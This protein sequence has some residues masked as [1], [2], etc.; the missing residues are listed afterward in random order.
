MK[1]YEAL[2]NENHELRMENASLRARLDYAE[3]Q[4]KEL[5]ADVAAVHN[6]DACGCDYDCF[7]F[8]EDSCPDEAEL[9]FDMEVI[10]AELAD[11]VDCVVNVAK[12][13]GTKVATS[14]F[15]KNVLNGTQKL[16]KK[17]SDGIESL[18]KKNED[19][20]D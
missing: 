18:E 15:A 5:S 11:K 19:S 8:D 2:L 14:K 13:V 4:V 17:A 10:K 9:N 12:S 3:A 20:E 6:C 16:L 7:P 1:S